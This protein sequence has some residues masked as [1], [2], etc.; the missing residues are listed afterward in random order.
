MEKFP[1]KEHFY[2][3]KPNRT[4]YIPVK[5]EG[6]MLTYNLFLYVGYVTFNESM[7]IAY[8]SLYSNVI[9]LYVDIITPQSL[10]RGCFV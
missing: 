7:Y 4:R 10:D 5:M 1:Y 2:D 3:W 8:M 6:F 9:Y